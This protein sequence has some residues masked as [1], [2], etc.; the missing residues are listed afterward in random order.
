MPQV[1]NYESIEQGEPWVRAR[2]RNRRS[3][4]SHSTPS[5]LPPTEPVREP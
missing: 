2:L 3:P 5:A 4:P 1:F